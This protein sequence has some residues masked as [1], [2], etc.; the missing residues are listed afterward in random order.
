[1]KCTFGIRQIAYNTILDALD[2]YLQMGA[3]TA[4]D[5]L[6]KHGFPGM[7]GIIVC[8]DWSWE[9]C[10]VAFRARF[11]KG[12]HGPDPFILGSAWSNDYKRIMYKTAHEAARKDVEH[13]FGVLK[14]KCKIIKQ[15][16][17]DSEKAI[18]PR[19][20]PEEKHRD[21]DLV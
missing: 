12:D 5:S 19:F 7:I 9:N 2:E 21:D 18:S 4:H 8:T 10:P 13:A 11:C 1:M 6:E 15:Q 3:T 17:R 14:T 20:Y 16:A